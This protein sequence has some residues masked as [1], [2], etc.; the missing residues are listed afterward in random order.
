MFGGG[1]AS[2]KENDENDFKKQKTDKCKSKRK[3][4]VP[5]QHIPMAID[6]MD[7]VIM[8]DSDDPN[9][10]DYFDNSKKPSMVQLFLFKS[11]FFLKFLKC[12]AF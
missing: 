1:P 11:P 6:N 9:D 7:D 8:A 10:S 3:S 4:K 12:P 2:G 5:H